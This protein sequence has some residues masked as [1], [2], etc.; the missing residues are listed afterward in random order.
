LF[1]SSAFRLAAL[2]PVAFC[3]AAFRLPWQNMAKADS[4]VSVWQAP[5]AD[6]P[7]PQSRVV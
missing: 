6:D 4:I 7:T 5:S 2:L 3:G 1:F